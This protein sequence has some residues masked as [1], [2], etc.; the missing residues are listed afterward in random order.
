MTRRGWLIGLV[1]GGLL[2][3]G[4][5]LVVLI[6]DS[7]R[8]AASEPL[9]PHPDSPLQLVALGDSYISG[10]GA[11]AYFP[12]TDETDKD[13]R[14][15]CHR[16][17]SAYPYLIADELGMSLRFTACS[18]ARVGDVIGV[19]A[20]GRPAPP[21]YPL[22]GEGVY[23]GHPQVTVLEN[24]TSPDAVLL[25]VGGN[26]AGFSEIG[27]TCAL[28][29]RPCSRP[30][31]AERWLRRLDTHVYPGLV[32]TYREV[33]RAARGVPVFVLTYP[34]P[35]GPRYCRQLIGVEPDE[36]AFLRDV[37]IGE[38]NGT[39][40]AAAKAEGVEVIDLTGALDGYRFCDKE[41]LSE[42][43]INFAKLGRTT[44]TRF[45]LAA[46]IRGSLHPNPRGHRLFRD[47]VLE[48]ISAAAGSAEP[49]AQ[50]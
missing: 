37:F 10:E 17:P 49:T 3:A 5:L 45:D 1:L 41:K 43:A 46:L 14:N 21:Q 24:L 40:K 15:L 29:P 7:S 4:V 2:V 26:D 35:F 25:S 13:R 44:G 36:M 6:D 31:T 38:L 8:P 16:A 32:R 34:N 47:E 23:G 42:T 19:D 28:A 50:R 22:S 30:E 9:D 27:R 12:G 48:E 18:G 33:R 11:E 20:E 39:V